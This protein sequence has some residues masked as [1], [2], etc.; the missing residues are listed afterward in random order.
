MDKTPSSVI[1]EEIRTISAYPVPDSRGLVKLDAMENP[2]GL[3]AQLREQ[4]AR[5]AAE[6]SLNRY[7][8][9]RAATL[10]AQLRETMRIPDGMELLLGNGSDELIQILALAVNRPSAVL[11][12]VEP[13]F[14]MFRLVATFCGMR[15]VA[16]PLTPEFALDLP[17]LRA[18]VLEYRPAL[19]FIAY[20]NNPT[21]NLFDADAMRELIETSPGLVVVDEAYHA[22]AS[23]SF[24][25]E[26]E[27]YSNL[28]VMR[29]LSKLGLAG[30]RL[31]MLIGSPEWLFE[32]DKLRLPYNVSV[33][34][35]HIA[36]CVLR[37][38]DVLQTQAA[39]ICN[40]RAHLLTALQALPGVR[41]FPSQAN[42]ILFRAPRADAVFAGLKARGVLIKNLHG[43]HPSLNDCLRVTVG[44]PEENERFLNA[45]Q[46][47]LPQA[48]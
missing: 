28:L 36:A 10:K 2:Y 27:R 35:Q 7:P 33:L 9:P 26:L 16:V 23:H 30:L 17:Q 24:L 41:A 3:P 39:A 43:S 22:F 12:G 44:T 15:Y 4:V 34:T 46:Q 20:P 25:P 18:A 37:R 1:R 19:T 13:S 45:L 38:P 48:A 21:G 11:L 40:A 5:L 47:S 31:G 14:V 32:L 6:A 8:D 42:F 29:T